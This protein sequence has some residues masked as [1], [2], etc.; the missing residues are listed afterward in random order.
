[1]L[2]E[3]DSEWKEEFLR[4][5]S[6]I[7]ETTGLEERRI[8]HIGSTAIEGMPSKPIID[9]MV[10]MD[11]LE[12]VDEYLVYG[13]KRVG[14]LR[15]IVKRDN[16]IIFAKFTDQTYEIKTHIIHM[17]E[18]KGELWHNLLFFRDYLNSNAEARMLYF[19]L[20]QNYIEKSNTGINDYTSSKEG[21]VKEIF[22]KR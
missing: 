21:F 5:K 3:Y 18:Y 12:Q 19:G 15:L 2:V 6:E 8:Q 11:D 22:D 20:K 10:G 1:M 9:L 14:F 17:V 16:E 7:V 4:V 13:L